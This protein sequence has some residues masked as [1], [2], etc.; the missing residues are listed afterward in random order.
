MTM[1]HISYLCDG[2]GRSLDHV[3]EVWMIGGK[4]YCLRCVDADRFNEASRN[5]SRAYIGFAFI[6][7][8]L[9]MAFAVA[10]KARAQDN[11]HHLYHADYYSQWHQLGSIVSPPWPS[12]EVLKVASRCRSHCRRS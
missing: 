7:A 4:Q 12:F 11:G 1:R 10:S 2:C 3:R 8:L 6:I 5:S 9:M